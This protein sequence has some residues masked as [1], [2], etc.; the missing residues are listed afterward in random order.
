VSQ[1]VTVL[2]RCRLPLPG[3]ASVPPHNRQGP[4]DLAPGLYRGG[5]C[6][7]LYP[8]LS[9]GPARGVPAR[10]VLSSPGESDQQFRQPYQEHAWALSWGAPG[11]CV[12]TSDICYSKNSHGNPNTQQDPFDSCGCG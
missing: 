9:G 4:R 7:S 2:I 12:L 3:R 5:Q 8:V 11:Q 1:V 6:D 10:A